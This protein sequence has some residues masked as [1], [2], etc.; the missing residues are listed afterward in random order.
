MLTDDHRPEPGKS[1]AIIDVNVDFEQNKA[2]VA[3][4][5]PDLE[6]VTGDKVAFDASASSDPDGTILS[7]NWDFGDGNR[8][9]GI[10]P[11]HIYQFPGEYIVT[12]SI[13]G[14][15]AT[16]AASAA[17]ML[18]VT[19]R[20]PG[21]VAPTAIGGADLTVAPGQV[22]QFDGSRSSDIDGNIVA[23]QW[24]FSNGETA[25][26]PRPQYTFHEEGTY[27]VRLKVTDDDA[28][29]PKTAEDE[30]SVT[31]RAV[32]DGAGGNE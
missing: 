24:D 8:S 13:R 21:N 32:K 20:D 31:V 25:N 10:A 22:I 23:Y 30:V 29:D 27:L 11:D 28:T 6:A 2:P 3:V 16:S 9:T 18:K 17:D 1:R 19:V 7:Y 15:H 12:V 5:G 4:L 26:V 14:S